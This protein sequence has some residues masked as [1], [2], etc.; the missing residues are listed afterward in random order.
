[1]A[2]ALLSSLLDRHGKLD[3]AL[4]PERP[5]EAGGID[6]PALLQAHLRHPGNASICSS[7]LSGA[8][9]ASPAA[10]RLL[11][12]LAEGQLDAS[13]YQQ[14]GQIGRGAFASVSGATKL[15]GGTLH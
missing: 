15:R 4:V 3:P 10:A 14:L 5:A 8:E 11:R 1:M 6:L 2:A 13:G 9:H 7:T 12:I